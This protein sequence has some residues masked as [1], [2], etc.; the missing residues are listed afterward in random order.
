VQ[1]G[2]V[3]SSFRKQSMLAKR[4]ALRLA[5]TIDPERSREL[6]RE[7][8]DRAGG[9]WGVL[10]GT[11]FPPLT[12]VHAWQVGALARLS[13][14]G[15]GAAS[16]SVD[17]GACLAEPSA[18]GPDVIDFGGRLRRAVWGQ[19]ARIA[20]RELVP[21][22]EGGPDV[23]ETA[24][25]LSDLASASLEVALAEAQDFVSARMGPPRRKDGRISALSAFGLGKLGAR[26]LNA[27]SD[28]DLLLVYDSDDGDGLSLNEY[29]ARVTRRA[30]ATLEQLTADG[31]V[32]RVD[33]RLRPEGSTGALVNSVSALERYYETWGRLWERVALLRA[34]PVAGDREL[35]ELVV[36]EVFLPFVYRG[37]VDPTL[38]TALLE[39]VERAR[40]ELCQD[41]RR[42]L[43]LGIG[44]IRDAEFFI[45]ALQ[46]IWGGVEPTLRVN[47]TLHA[48]ERL[49]SR[50]LVTSKES[51]D[52]ERAY[53]LLRR[54]EHRVQWM[55]GIQTHLL[56][57]DEAELD[58]LARSVWLD[59]G[60]RLMEELDEARA[61]MHALLIALPPTA[62]RSPSRYRRL[63]SALEHREPELDELA[64]SLLAPDV[65]EH[66]RGL[67][68]R[69]DDPLGQLA[70]DRF[71]DLGDEI[72]DGIAGAPDPVQAALYLRSFFGRFHSP[73]AQIAP[74]VDDP[75]ALQRLIYVFG[76]SSL[77]GEA[78]VARPDLADIVL[79][80]GR[81]LCR[82]DPLRTMQEE[83][84]ALAHEPADEQDS[85]VVRAG[86]VRA[87]R[88]SK[89]KVTV[90]VAVA[91]LAGE[92]S[93]REVTRVLS[94]LADAQI[95]AAVGHALGVQVSS[96][97]ED[98]H[99]LAAIALG[100]LGG[101]DIGYGSDLDVIFIYDPACAPRG[102]DAQ[103][104]YARSAQE[105]VRILT[106]L[107]PAGPGYELDTRL[108]PDGAHGLLVTS[109]EQFARYH[110]VAFGDGDQLERV[111]T[112]SA[113]WERLA[114]IRARACAG[115]RELGRRVIEIAEVAAYEQ[116]PPE[117]RELHRLRR[118]LES[119]LG[120][121]REDRYNVKLGYGGLLDIEF[122]VQWLQMSHGKDPSVRTTNTLD[123]LQRLHEQGYVS[124]ERYAT[125]HQA[126]VFLRRLEQ[127]MRVAHGGGAA[128]IID[129]S[130]SALRQLARRMGI[131]GS[132][133]AS[134]TH[135]LIQRY[136]ATTRE[137]RRAYLATLAL[138][139]D[140]KELRA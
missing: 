51:A 91:D 21:V 11:A 17:L 127:R 2:Q 64:D 50:G 82:V 7:L 135:V 56:P 89:V 125:L 68:R 31:F 49:R 104:Y 93:M 22:L 44:G 48:L 106:G 66:L 132:T 25:E 121:E 28:I 58:R 111:E 9:G 43:K 101:Q 92:L 118:R 67:A 79:F 76:A 130:G 83:L 12:P 8:G 45:H 77:V 10:L 115:D 54:I 3:A 131:H 47:G 42:D 37:A 27:G 39:L 140:G 90:D 32:W 99:G 133:D 57:R 73:A 33:L 75:P 100:K 126:Y 60:A 96:A 102:R 105:I 23:D 136:R 128:P 71:P 18:T 95:H 35:G 86:I 69:P 138:A 24:R 98:V 59:S 112:T 13:T 78:L 139:G 80:R 74:L 14:Q 61:R 119:E 55:T 26:E 5:D 129:A 65:G 4:K 36:R 70:I 6:R 84:A 117:P 134:E 94:G 1:V 122:A 20:L 29:W 38:A 114:L 85:D 110:R 41:Q 34:R 19:K 81:E 107:N 137:V 109:L 103:D 40:S 87:L 30:T 88:R 97:E 113:D 108:R 46:L 52:V 16:Q 116:G 53:L 123:A 124:D 120:G 63:L 72:L 15:L 62:P